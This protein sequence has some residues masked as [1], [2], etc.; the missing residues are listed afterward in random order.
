MEL[1]RSSLNAQHGAKQPG[2]G[3]MFT[4][5]PNPDQMHGP[6]HSAAQQMGPPA[7]GQ[8]P[9]QNGQRRLPTLAEVNEKRQ[10]LQNAIGR[11]EQ[12]ISQLQASV[13]TGSIPEHIYQ[14]RLPVLRNELNARKEYLNKLNITVA[15]YANQQMFNGMVPSNMPHM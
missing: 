12:E 4:L 11:A 7:G 13:R 9:A 3:D 6:P 2:N 8:G 10:T 5:P 15:H 14:Q 1:A